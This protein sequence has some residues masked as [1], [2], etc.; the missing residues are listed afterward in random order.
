MPRL[1]VMPHSID[2]LVEQSETP[3]AELAERSGLSVERID[4]IVHGRWTPSP[5]ERRR[6]A[7]T[8]GVD[9]EAVSWGHTMSPRNVRY[10]RYGIAEEFSNRPPCDS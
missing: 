10:H 4:A 2:V 6:L 9:V 3:L 7:Q 8:L 1:F 5:D